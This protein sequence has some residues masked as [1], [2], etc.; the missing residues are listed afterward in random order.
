M[1]NDTVSMD[2]VSG[3]DYPALSSMF[4]KGDLPGQIRSVYKT[5]ETNA[6]KVK[7]FKK[8]IADGKITL[9]ADKLTPSLLK[10][11]AELGVDVAPELVD[12]VKANSRIK[13]D[14]PAE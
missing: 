3:A 13:S 5:R 2:E 6:A 11:L 1:T 14:K 7:D 4:F 12:A 8:A 10:K 9:S